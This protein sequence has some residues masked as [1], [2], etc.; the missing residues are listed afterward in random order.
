MGEGLFEVRTELPHNRIARV[1]FYVDKKEQ[2]VLLHALIKKS[3]ATPDE[4][5]QLARK[6]KAKHARGL[7]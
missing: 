3:R 7:S 1:L 4:D 5:L 6:N 2:M